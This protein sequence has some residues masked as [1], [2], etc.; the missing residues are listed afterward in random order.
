[1]SYGLKY[2]FQ[3]TNTSTKKI[4]IHEWDYIGDSES[5][6]LSKPIYLRQ[7]MRGGRDTVD[8]LVNGEEWIFKIQTKTDNKTYYDDLFDS[9]YKDYLVKVYFGSDLKKVGYLKTENLE[10]SYNDYAFTLSLSFTDA[11]AD[12]KDIPFE[13]DDGTFYRGEQTMLWTIKEALSKI[14]TDG[15]FQLP[16]RIASNIYEKDLMSS[17][18]NAL[19]HCDIPT[20]RFFTN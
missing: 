1:M 20:D 12:L 5:I 16:F 3:Y 15:E 18:E 11:L 10:R 13:K 9:P 6:P 8:Q 4:E 19:Y 7:K 17:D 2:T 14:D